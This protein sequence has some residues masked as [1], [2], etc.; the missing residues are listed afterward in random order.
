MA[1][2]LS[3][4]FPLFRHLLLHAFIMHFMHIVR[5]YVLKS[6]LVRFYNIYSSMSNAGIPV[7]PFK[8]CL[9]TFTKE[10]F[11]DFAHA[12]LFVMKKA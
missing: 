2:V 11:Y 3:A 5:S 10:I 6:Y 9:E 1:L 12:T 8:C 4:H 7:S